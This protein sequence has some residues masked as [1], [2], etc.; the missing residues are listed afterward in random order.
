MNETIHTGEQVHECAKGFNAD[1]FAC[2]D[3]SNHHRLAESFNAFL[4]NFCA[5]AIGGCNV[6][7][8]VFFNV[9]LHA[10]FI[11]QGAD[12]LAAGTDERT[13]L[14]HR[15]FHGDD[16]WGVR[17]QICTRFSQRSQHLIHN[18]HACGA[19]LFESFLHHLCA[20]AR[21]LDVHL[22]S[23]DA[24]SGSSYL[25]IHIAEVIFGSLNI[26]EDLVA[27]SRIGDETHCH[28]RDRSLDRHAC[29]HQREG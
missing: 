16:A 23:G 6:N 20:Q 10:S 19:S 13:D 7:S 8:A 14:V 21:D 22:Q 5:H 2:V 25:E 11:L 18:G 27:A 12:V 24:G 9:D 15:D 4:G 1:H 17:L 26:G 3:V 28:A 29:I